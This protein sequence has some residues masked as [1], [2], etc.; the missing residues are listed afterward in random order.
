MILLS[1]QQIKRAISSIQRTF[2]VNTQ[3]WTSYPVE[4]VLALAL[5]TELLGH[6]IDKEGIHTGEKTH[7]IYVMLTNQVS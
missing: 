1:I 6:Y 5:R 7:K 2:C 4:E 3:A